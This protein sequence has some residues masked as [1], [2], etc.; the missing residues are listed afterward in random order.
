[1][2]SIHPAPACRL[3]SITLIHLLLI[4]LLKDQLNSQQMQQYTLLNTER[5]PIP[6]A[7]ACV[8]AQAPE[9]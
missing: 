7:T 8:I 1:M 5:T 3:Y 6:L 2:F 4:L 9:T